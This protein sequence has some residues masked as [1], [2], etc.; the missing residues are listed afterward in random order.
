MGLE[1]ASEWWPAASVNW[2]VRSLSACD[3][4]ILDIQ[5]HSLTRSL[6][7]LIHEPESMRSQQSFDSVESGFV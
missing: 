7:T 6:Y 4:S 1:R 2:A 3:S 5:C